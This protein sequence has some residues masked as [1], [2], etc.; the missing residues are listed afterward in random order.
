M[1]GRNP[2]NRK[3]SGTF[4]SLPHHVQDS[5]SF[6][7]LS[8]K[9]VKLLINML[10]DFNGRNNGDLS[11]AL[12]IMKHRGWKS[13]SHIVLARKELAEKGLIQLTRQGETLI[14]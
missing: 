3:K 4:S 13:D 10:R 9:A 7:S 5:K 6:C 12:G 14:G 2:S 1:S 11:S 8:P